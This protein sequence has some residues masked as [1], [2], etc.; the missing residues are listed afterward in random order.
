MY[1]LLERKVEELCIVFFSKTFRPDKL[2]DDTLRLQIQGSLPVK[3][4]TYPAEKDAEKESGFRYPNSQEM[5]PKLLVWIELYSFTS[6]EHTYNFFSILN[7][8][9]KQYKAPRD[10]DATKINQFF[11]ARSG[12]IR[13]SNIELAGS[14]F[15]L[16]LYIFSY[17]SISQDNCSLEN[18]LGS[19]ARVLSIV[20]LPFDLFPL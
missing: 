19:S 8:V 17:Y 4:F 6:T 1:L 12:M 3:S 5:T 20:E 14:R 10:D 11:S 2:K 7:L 15:T 16:E 13:E 9:N 18:H